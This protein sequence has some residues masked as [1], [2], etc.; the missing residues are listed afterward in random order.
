MFH[1]FRGCNLQVAG[2]RL[3]VQFN[4]YYCYDD[5]ET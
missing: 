2:C 5:D 4:D 1:I 3:Q